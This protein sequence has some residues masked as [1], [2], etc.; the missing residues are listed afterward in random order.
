MGIKVILATGIARS[1]AVKIA[2]ETGILRP[3]HE[4][5]CG[6]VIEGSELRNI[7]N[8]RPRKGHQDDFDITPEYLSVVYKATAEDR[9]TLVDYLAKVHPGRI[10]A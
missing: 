1:D 5:I 3:E 10:T 2:I 4:K 7:Y 9:C 6:A 8:G